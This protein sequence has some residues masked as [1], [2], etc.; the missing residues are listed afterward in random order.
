[1]NVVPRVRTPISAG[2]AARSVVASYHE[3]FGNDPTKPAL[4]AVLSLVWLETG[5]GE[6]V[7]NNNL[8]N[9][10]AGDSFP[11]DA[12]RPPWFDFDGG[13]AVTEQNIRLHEKMLRG[14]APKA[15]RAYATREAGALDFVRQ[16]RGAFPEVL[17]AAE[18]SD[19]EAFRVA[20]SQK[21][22]H[23]YDD[24]KFTTSFRQLFAEFDRQIVDPDRPDQPHSIGPFLVALGVVGAAGAIFY[25]TLRPPRLLRAPR[26]AAA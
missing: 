25:F 23:A 11:G 13:T 22:S 17:A 12:W 24:P 5:R 3:L 21:Y 7:Q 4:V 10:S 8:G 14:E 15:F 9:L 2:D 26:R 18:L 19:P 20:L 1:M 6:S 16:L